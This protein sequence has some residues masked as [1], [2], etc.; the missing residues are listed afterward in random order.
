VATATAGRW[1][2]SSRSPRDRRPRPAPAHAARCPGLICAGPGREFAADGRRAGQPV[3]LVVYA[4]TA[5]S[6]DA[7]F[8]ELPR[9]STGFHANAECLRLSASSM[10]AAPSTLGGGQ[11][12]KHFRKHTSDI[13]VSRPNNLPIRLTPYR[14]QVASR[15]NS[16]RPHPVSCR[17]AIQVLPGEPRLHGHQASASPGRSKARSQH[18]VG[19]RAGVRPSVLYAPQSGVTCYS[20]LSPRCVGGPLWAA[21]KSS[22]SHQQPAERFVSRPNGR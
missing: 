15:S 5:R 20:A 2:S 16:R 19:H 4:D 6:A 11:H 10:I 12:A 13:A 17:Y 18:G 3:G 1:R 8:E 22:P 7:G 14:P 21:S 9:K